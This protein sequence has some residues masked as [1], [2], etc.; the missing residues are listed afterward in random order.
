MV[1]NS[2]RIVDDISDGPSHHKP[3]RELMPPP[4]LLLLLSSAANDEYYTDWFN[5]HTGQPGACVKGR[6]LVA[7]VVRFFVPD[8]LALL[9]TV[10]DY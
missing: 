10:S 5:I 1:S 8:R 9:A 6:L 4:L 2:Y 3:T 7:R